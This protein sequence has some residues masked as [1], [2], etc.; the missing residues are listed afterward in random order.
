MNQ[1]RINIEKIEEEDEEIIFPIRQIHSGISVDDEFYG[2]ATEIY[3]DNSFYIGEFEKNIKNGKGKMKFMN[4]IEYEGD[5]IDGYPHGNG[6][7]YFN[8]KI[9]YRGQYKYGKKTLITPVTYRP[10]DL[11]LYL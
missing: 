7:F 10:P 8:S 9:I 6:I 4:D 11:F 2:E 1:K 3:K 5:W